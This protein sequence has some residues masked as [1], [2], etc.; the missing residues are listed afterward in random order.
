MS[1]AAHGERVIVI[2]DAANA[3]RRAALAEKLAKQSFTLIEP[4]GCKGL[5]GG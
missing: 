2:G 5:Q 3:N 1:G 4:V